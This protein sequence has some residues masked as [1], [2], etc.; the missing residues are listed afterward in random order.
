MTTCVTN[1]SSRRAESDLGGHGMS[2]LESARAMNYS[3]TN[4]RSASK[5]VSQRRSSSAMNSFA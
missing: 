4:L 3:S 2:G 5:R 1:I